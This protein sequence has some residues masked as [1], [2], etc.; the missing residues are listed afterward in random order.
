[1]CACF[2]FFFFFVFCFLFQ[3]YSF[4]YLNCHK[5]LSLYLSLSL[6]ISLYCPL[7]CILLLPLY[8][9]LIW[10]LLVPYVQPFTSISFLFLLLFYK[11]YGTTFVVLLACKSKLLKNNHSN[12][13]RHRANGKK[14]CSILQQFSGRQCLY[15]KFNHLLEYHFRFCSYFTKCTGQPLLFY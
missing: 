8:C 1:M 15:L 7:I 2:F 4:I 3:P 12:K 14:S 10:K 9:P 5:S 6:S 13:P 11:M